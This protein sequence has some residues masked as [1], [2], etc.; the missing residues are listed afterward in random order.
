[1]V[2]GIQTINDVEVS[3][4]NVLCILYCRYIFLMN[5][6]LH[7]QEARDGIYNCS[8]AKMSS[9]PEQRRKDALNDPEVQ[10]T[11]CMISEGNHNVIIEALWSCSKNYSG[12]FKLFD[13]KYDACCCMRI[14]KELIV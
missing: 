13:E 2:W 9:D 10:V 11:T 6:L 12:N 7:F 14:L 1:M 5:R 8:L 4:V 3:N